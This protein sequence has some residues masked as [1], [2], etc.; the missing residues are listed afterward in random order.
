MYLRTYE[1]LGQADLP[2]IYGTPCLQ[3]DVVGRLEF[4]LLSE[5]ITK[6][7]DD[8]Y[9]RRA[10][11]RTWHKTWIRRQFVP[12]IVASWSTSK[13]IRT[14]ILIGDADE[15]GDPAFNYRLGKARAEAVSKELTKQ[16]EDKSRGLSGKIT[17]EV[18]SRGEC[19]P[20]VKG[21]KRES[22]NR[23]VEVFAVKAD[24]TVTVKPPKPPIPPSKVPDLR[25]LTDATKKRIEELDRQ[26]LERKRFDPIP[27][28][29]PGQSLSDWL[30]EKL[31]RVPSWLRTRMRDAIVK[32]A[33]AALATLAEQ[34]G[35]TGPEK[36]ALQ[37]MCKAAAKT[38]SR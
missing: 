34:A 28:P 1:P 15:V 14:I 22:R 29:R 33:C 25:R 6:T 10:S 2:S 4:A 23:R 18:Y 36:E 12:V 16:I 32:G 19:W 17:I 24:P 11:L 3:D 27:G 30:D 20:A 13:P 21:G 37:S 7:L 26:A 31:H 5:P 35:L 8:F 9:F 38:P